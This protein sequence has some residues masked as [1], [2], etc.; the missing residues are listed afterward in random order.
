MTQLSPFPHRT[1]ISI[2]NCPGRIDRAFSESE[3]ELAMEGYESAPLT[4]KQVIL[5]FHCNIPQMFLFWTGPKIYTTLLIL[6][7]S[8]HFIKNINQ[9]WIN[10]PRF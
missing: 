3:T 8:L 1:D 6:M 2:L 7:P 9:D 10:A 4:N 5:R